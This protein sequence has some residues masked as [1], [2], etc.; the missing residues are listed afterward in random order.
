MKLHLYAL[1]IPFLVAEAARA[2]EPSPFQSGYYVSLAYANVST[3]FKGGGAQDFSL[4]NLNV[5]WG[6]QFKPNF[7]AEF[8]GSFNVG[9]ETDD[10]VSDLLG[11]KVEVAYDSF[12]IFGVGKY[13]EKF[14]VSG[15][16]GLAS[17]R[18]T[19]SAKGYSDEKEDDIGLAYGLGGGI[20]HNKLQFE[21][22][23]I[24]LPEVDD[25]IFEDASYE[26]SMLAFG[27]NYRF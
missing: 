2:Q 15:R 3:D 6:Y 4:Q 13:G 9:P 1:M 11:Q 24:V 21:V 19:Y 10:F 23:F 17:S 8:W 27:I 25:P 12:G 22:D 7:A 26:N 18:F 5:A 20:S 14:Y 16:L